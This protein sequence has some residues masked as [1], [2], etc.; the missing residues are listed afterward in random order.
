MKKIGLI[1]TVILF[2]LMTFTGCFLDLKTD[3]GSDSNKVEGSASTNKVEIVGTPTMEVSY[4][5]YLGYS[6]EISGTLKNSKNKDYSYVSVEFSIYDAQGN[7]IGS[8]LDNMNN[9]G[10]GETW[11]FCASSLGWFDDE[12]VKFKLADITYF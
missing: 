6:V 12:P 4:S 11:K 3:S 9:L 8:A 10:E 5:E 2:S 7:N 1:L